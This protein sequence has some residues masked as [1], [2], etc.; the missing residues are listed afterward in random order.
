MSYA[1][2]A[3]IVISA[4]NT[5]VMTLAV[6]I[7]HDLRSRIM[8]LENLMMSDPKGGEEDVASNRGGRSGVSPAHR[9]G[10]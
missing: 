1:D 5:I 7:L 6:F 2:G 10:N 3:A 9:R 8:R 4:A